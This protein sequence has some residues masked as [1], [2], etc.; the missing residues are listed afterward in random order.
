MIRIVFFDVDGTLM[1]D[2]QIPDS[3]RQAVSLLKE[4]GIIPALATGRPEYEMRAVCESLGIDWAV[5]CNGAHIGYQG[6]TIIGTP[7]SKAQIGEWVERAVH[8]ENHTLLLYGGQQIYSTKRIADCPYF[9]EA[10]HEIGFLE[11]LPVTTA[12]ELPDIYQCILFA[13]E[14]DEAPYIA[15]G[16]DKLYLH[17]WRSSALDL[18]PC[19][20]NKS[21]GVTQLLDHLGLTREQ[22]AA[23][24][25]GLN[26]LEM[27]RDI[28]HGI[29]MGNSCPELLACARYVT[30]HVQEDGIL[31]GVKRWILPTIV[32]S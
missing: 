7:F 14:E 6:N 24:G 3:A 28:G 9:T 15:D 20:V 13:P 21:T 8:S 5:T 31:H 26:D 23:F 18:N 16:A 1:T 27:I 11:P 17:R 22:A 12:D 19:G 4:Q 29:A 32:H 10:D 30:R 2:R 25:D